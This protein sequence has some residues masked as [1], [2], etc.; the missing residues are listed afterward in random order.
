[1]HDLGA[2]EELQEEEVVS[3]EGGVG[4][5]VDEVED[6][7]R[8][9]GEGEGLEEGVD[10]YPEVGVQAEEGSG[11]EDA[12]NPPPGRHGA[13]AWPICRGRRR[14]RGLRGWRRG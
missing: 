3:E 10:L 12:P 9:E 8:E 14:D 13:C 6:L 2:G 1:M 11:A 7:G 5:S 4:D